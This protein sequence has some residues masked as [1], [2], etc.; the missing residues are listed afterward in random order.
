MASLVRLRATASHG[1]GVRV[2]VLVAHKYMPGQMPTDELRATFAA[3]R[4]TLDYLVNSLREQTRSRTLT[5]Y[6]ITGPRGAGKTTLV[7]MLCLRIEEELD[8]R[9]AWLPIRF[10]EE[11][12][13]VT[14]LRDL[15]AAA[16]QVLAEDGVP[17]AREWSTKVEAELDER[18]SRDLAVAGLR[19][20]AQSQ[21]RRLVLFV[22]NLDVIFERGLDEDSQATLRR[23][24]MTE[25]FM[26]MVGT[27]VHVFD[28]LRAYDRAFFNYFCPVPLER[29]DDDQVYEL[30]SRRAQYDGNAEFEE[31]Y[32]RE[33]PKVQAISR[34][35]GGNPRLVL[36]LYE[37]LGQRSIGSVVETLRQLVDEL[38]PLLKDV[39]EHQLAGQ[40]S[41]I[42]DAVMRAGGT[43]TPAE[44]ARSTRL[45]LN[46]VTTQLRRLRDGQVVDVRGGGKGRTAYYT[47][48][49]P[50][51][52]VW[53]QM[54]YLRPQRR[55]IEMFVE[56]LRIWF[57]TEERV[58]ALRRL[59][60]D[61][62]AGGKA[63]REM[64]VAAE[65]Y[66]ASL[67]GSPYSSTAEEI[68]VKNW[69][70]VG[71][72]REAALALAEF[73]G[74]G[75]AGAEASEVGA[76]AGLGRWLQNQGGVKRSVEAL[77]AAVELD[78]DDV[79]LRL[80][81]GV[82]LGLSGNHEAA[83]R[84]FD[85]ALRRTEDPDVRAQALLNRGVSRSF[86]GDRVAAIADYMAVVELAGAATEQVARALF[87]KGVTLGA[88]GRSEEAVRVYDDV[89][90][91]FGDR[92]EPALA[93]QVA[94]ALVNRG[95]AKRQH[96]EVT[97]AITDYNAALSLDGIPYDVRAHAL[98]NRAV[99]RISQGDLD[100]ALSDWLVVIS[101][102][103]APSSMRLHATRAAFKTFWRDKDRVEEILTAL[104]AALATLGLDERAE[105][106][107]RLLASLSSPDMRE[108]WPT[109]WRAI[110]G[111]ER[112]ESA[113]Q[114]SFFTAIA[115]VLER[116]GDLSPLDPLPPEQREFALEVLKKFEPPTPEQPMV[117][118]APHHPPDQGASGAAT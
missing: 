61:G 5:S 94:R 87:N 30:L 45:S 79:G 73:R 109:V 114:L 21:K 40:Q 107:V 48:T 55:K 76:Y 93:E 99:A 81:Y 71:D 44:L 28:D 11:L 95:V 68:A 85:E 23:L 35:A 112:P 47:V 10:P 57:E 98:S 16:L 29:L 66:A 4:H 108:G 27:A 17:G 37:I 43:A 36:M 60:V 82:A 89:V 2:M 3:R 78:P 97:G 8:L 14:S 22:E 80:D 7:L 56:V 106:L 88:L 77:R 18:R 65:Y 102:D 72:L 117:P 32:R 90:T 39:V 62:G 113:G 91:R 116:H 46:T 13:S 104:L 33:R 49:D 110:L 59:V 74:Q 103:Q 100:Q 67:L 41:K 96:G 24:L 26:V 84:V 53:Y 86:I 69:L 25:P 51:F 31:R 1:Y 118:D 50:L 111:R 52:S 19:A 12:P 92:S 54:R 64:A 105:Q 83:F 75:T 20:V 6:L 63:P 38:T 101:E 58:T 34:L 42:L 70:A 15:L 9:A 115:E